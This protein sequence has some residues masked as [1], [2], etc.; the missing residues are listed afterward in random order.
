MDIA[1]TFFF[2]FLVYSYCSGLRNC[3]F[4]DDE[5]L[6][7]LLQIASIPWAVVL[8]IECYLLLLFKYVTMERQEIWWKMGVIQYVCFAI[9]Y[10]AWPCLL[11]PVRGTKFFNFLLKLIMCCCYKTADLLL[12]SGYLLLCGQFGVSWPSLSWYVFLLTSSVNCFG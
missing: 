5:C 3:L 7:I 1:R 8:W 9:C 2:F 6:L 4:V 10:A 12:K 11:L